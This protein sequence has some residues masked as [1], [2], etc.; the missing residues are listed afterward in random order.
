[1]LNIIILIRE[2]VKKL[3][4]FIENFA[5]K[6]GIKKVHLYSTKTTYNFYIKQEYKLI[7]KNRW[8]SNKINFTSYKMEKTLK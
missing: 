1:L 8:R 2:L 3:L 7:K 4:T 5:K 6:K